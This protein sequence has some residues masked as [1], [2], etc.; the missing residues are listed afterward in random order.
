LNTFLSVVIAAALSSS[1]V[2]LIHALFVLETPQ[3]ALSA[4]V[5]ALVPGVPLITA[6]A[7]SVK[8]HIAV[9]WARAAEAFLAIVFIA[10]GALLASRLMG[11]LVS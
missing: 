8:G 9:G 11:R 1:I 4:C 7:D 6:A 5:L 10:L 2:L 3:A